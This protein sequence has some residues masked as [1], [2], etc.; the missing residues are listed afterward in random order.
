MRGGQLLTEIVTQLGTTAVVVAITG[1]L[2]KTWISH[3]L[4]HFHTKYTHTFALKLEEARAAWAR[5][6]ARLN[7]HE[8]YLHTR[9]VCLIEEMHREAVDAELSLQQFLVSWWAFTNKDELLTRGLVSKDHF[10]INRSTSM[11]ESGKKFCEAYLKINSTLHKNAIFFKEDF[12]QAIRNAYEPFF[13]TILELDYDNPPSI[14][15]EFKDVV[16]AGSI[17]RRAV[18][19]LFR[20]MLGVSST[21]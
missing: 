16:E 17:P 5:D 13:H 11:E 21:N 15:E 1:W 10:D 18:I 9:R 8:N 12:I 6:I 19:E 7:I 20:A 4:E 3:Q 2:L 14:P